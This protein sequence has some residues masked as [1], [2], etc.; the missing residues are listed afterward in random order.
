MLYRLAHPELLTVL[1]AAEQVLAAL[2]SSLRSA[3]RCAGI[4]GVYPIRCSS[5]EVPRSV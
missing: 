5:C 4:C 3:A 1:A 2:A